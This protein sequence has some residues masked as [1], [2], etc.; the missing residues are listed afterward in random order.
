[1]ELQIHVHREKIAIALPF[2]LVFDGGQ[3]VEWIDEI[4]LQRRFQVEDVLHGV[5]GVMIKVLVVELVV[6]LRIE[7]PPGG[8]AERGNQEQERD[9]PELPHTPVIG[10]PSSI[11][12]ISPW[13]RPAGRSPSTSE[14]CMPVTVNS[15]MA[16]RYA[17][18]TRVW[19]EAPS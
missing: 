9:E 17:S 3:G 1:D 19:K 7:D 6:F 10:I 8:S 4:R 16:R 14:T 12:H 5:I 11:F 2:D 18:L 13:I 15:S